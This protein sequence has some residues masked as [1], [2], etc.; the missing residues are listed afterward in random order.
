M[1]ERSTFLASDPFTQETAMLALTRK[2]G[3]TIRIGEEIVVTVSQIKGNR[4]RISIEAPREARI[5]RGELTPH[6]ESTEHLIPLSRG[7]IK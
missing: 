3:E 7:V 1:S 2:E 4:V 6:E 5:L